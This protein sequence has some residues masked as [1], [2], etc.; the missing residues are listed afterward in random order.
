VRHRTSLPS[1]LI[2]YALGQQA[3]L[4]NAGGSNVIDE[5]LHVAV[6]GTA[7][8]SNKDGSIESAR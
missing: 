7:V 6:F 3:N 5:R 1:N 2:V 4:I 8:A